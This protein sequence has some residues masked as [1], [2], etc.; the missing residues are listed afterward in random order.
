MPLLGE[1]ITGVIRGLFTGLFDWFRQRK[2]EKDR[3]RADVMHAA[4]VGDAA[5]DKAEFAV[6]QEAEKARA[7]ATDDP[8]YFGP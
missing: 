1:A 6:K 4:N 2:A 7:K 3:E 5:A 8:L